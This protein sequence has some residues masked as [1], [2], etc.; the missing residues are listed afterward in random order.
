MAIEKDLL[1]QAEQLLRK[2]PKHPK[3]ASLRRAVS[4]AYYALFDLLTRDTSELLI[5]GNDNKQLRLL[6]RRVFQHTEM[7]NAARAFAGGN[8]PDVLKNVFPSPISPELKKIAQ[9]FVNLQ[10]ARHEADYDFTK[11]F[12]RHEAKE[13]VESVVDAF[14]VWKTIKKSPEARLFMVALLE[15][16][17]LRRR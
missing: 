8:L 12:T 4:S 10:V 16:D 5:K 14:Q 11:D 6:L 13:L 2:E 17:R 9:T 7:K 1:T 15:F 3:Q